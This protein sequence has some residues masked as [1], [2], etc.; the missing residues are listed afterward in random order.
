MQYMQGSRIFVCAWTEY[1]IPDRQTNFVCVCCMAVCLLSS[2]TKY[3]EDGV[4][5]VL[6]SPKYVAC[7]RMTRVKIPRSFALMCD[8]G[9]MRCVAA[10]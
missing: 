4:C 5:T 2:L 8:G 7:V 3:I 10:N 6:V 1:R 9:V